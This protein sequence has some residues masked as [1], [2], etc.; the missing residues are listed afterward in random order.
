MSSKERFFI[1]GNIL[2]FEGHASKVDSQRQIWFPQ[3][4]FTHDQERFRTDV[5]EGPL[6]NEVVLSYS[7]VQRPIWLLQDAGCIDASKGPLNN[8]VTPNY[9]FVQRQIWLLQRGCWLHWSFIGATSSSLQFRANSPNLKQVK[10]KKMRINLLNQ[11]TS[12]E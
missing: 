7:F 3:C 9:S 4:M 1:E 8:E 11:F 6:N 5:S 2:L 12:R 10:S